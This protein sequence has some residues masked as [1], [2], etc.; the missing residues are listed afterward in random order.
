M[1]EPGAREVIGASA[2]DLGIYLSPGVSLLDYD[3]GQKA[4]YMQ[5]RYVYADLKVKGYAKDNCDNV[6]KHE[7]V[8]SDVLLGGF[9]MLCTC[10][11][12]CVSVPPVN[13][14]PPSRIAEM[15]RA[16]PQLPDI[17]VEIPD[18]PL[19]DGVEILDDLE[20]DLVR[21][22]DEIADIG[23]DL[24]AGLTPVDSQVEYVN[25]MKIDVTVESNTA[26]VS[27]TRAA[28][29]HDSAFEL[30]TLNDLMI[31]HGYDP[32]DSSVLNEVR[33]G[34]IL[35][36]T[37]NDRQDRLY[38]SYY[39]YQKGWGILY[40]DVLAIPIEVYDEYIELYGEWFR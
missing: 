34:S 18:V 19:P 40:S 20:D 26:A 31:K 5:V 14:I 37:F 30:N 38:N 7:Q 8:I 4:W 3:C 25:I 1:G 9:Y 15:S 33:E 36:N 12:F 13:P 29:K 16:R 22:N 32:I 23:D 2:K 11:R 17:D 39:Q 27:P 6:Y 21:L 24:R 28:H 10:V 35:D